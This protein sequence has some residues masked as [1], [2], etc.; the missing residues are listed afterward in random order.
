MVVGERII[1]RISDNEEAWQVDTPRGP[2]YGFDSK[3]PQG[4]WHRRFWLPVHSLSVVNS[5]TLR[6]AFGEYVTIDDITPLIM[7]EGFQ[8]EPQVMIERTIV[9][10]VATFPVRESTI[11]PSCSV[12][13][14]EK[15]STS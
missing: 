6:V 3:T 5:R 15:L 14:T 1:S 9:K 13:E 10:P 2:I 11:Q 12:A 7:T 8:G 4:I